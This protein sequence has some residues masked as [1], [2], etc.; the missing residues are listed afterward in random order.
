MNQEIPYQ[1]QIVYR[2]TYKDKTN[3]NSYIT[4]EVGFITTSGKPLLGIKY[5][6]TNSSN[7]YSTNNYLTH[8]YPP[9]TPQDKIN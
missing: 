8:T 7:N 3:V 6:N 5:G 2:H 9:N 4:V 1:K